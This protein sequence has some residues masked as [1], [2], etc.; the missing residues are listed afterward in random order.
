MINYNAKQNVGYQN[1][2]IAFQVIIV[3]VFKYISTEKN[4]SSNEMCVNAGKGALL[5]A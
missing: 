1:T 4:L 2:W 5:D 3:S